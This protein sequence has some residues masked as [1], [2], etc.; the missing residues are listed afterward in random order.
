MDVT[1]VVWGGLAYEVV[2]EGGGPRA[3]ECGNEGDRA[4][5][6]GWRRDWSA[7]MACAA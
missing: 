5:G 6:V 1:M 7:S 3:W 2:A 4:Q